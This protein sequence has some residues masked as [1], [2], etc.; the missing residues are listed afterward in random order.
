MK[1]VKRVM[2]F[3]ALPALEEKRNVLVEEMETILKKT[4]EETRAFSDEEQTRFDAIK[5]EIESIDKTILADD[6]MRGFET[7][8]S[9]K[10]STEEEKRALDEKNFL[11]YI[12]TGQIRALGV[13]DNGAAII[14][15]EIAKSIVEKVKELSPIYQMATKFNV[16][17]DL[18]FPVEDTTTGKITAAYVDDLTE[19]IEGTGKFT[20]IKLQNHIV[21]ALAKIS[22]SLINR[23]GFDLLAYAVRK[24]AEAIA[25]FLEKEL[26]TG[27]AGKMKGL[28]TT[29]NTTLAAAV[30]AITADE[31]INLQLMVPESLKKTPGWIMHKDTFKAVRKLKYSGSGE[32]LMI[33][34]PT[35]KASWMLLGEPVYIS[36]NCPK[37]EAG[38]K[39]VFYGEFDGL[40]VKLANNVQVQ[41]LNEKYATQYA[42][43]AVGY[44]EVDSAI[45]ETQKIAALLMDDGL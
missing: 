1:N 7:K 8:K 17:G 4:K 25:E 30:N 11:D 40:Y 32:Y 38:N 44:V 28:I 16:S 21:G 27:N 22:K 18:Q 12:R 37:M 20:S 2:E 15:T 36:E 14:P 5:K 33:K 19:L 31:L 29:T 6:E 45:V 9:A 23:S 34:D 24:I 13:T 10:K 26:I 3:R 42:V 35:Q 41:V 43:G 39:A